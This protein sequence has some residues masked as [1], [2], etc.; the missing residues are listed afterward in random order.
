M[1]ASDD[2]AA[3]I[4][5]ATMPRLALVQAAALTERVLTTQ[6]V[7]PAPRRAPDAEPADIAVDA[8]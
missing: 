1:I 7:I 6:G 4:D 5:P 3:P 2:D 8:G